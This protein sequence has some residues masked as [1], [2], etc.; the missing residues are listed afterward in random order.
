[1]G[2]PVIYPDR[3]CFLLYIDECLGERTDPRTHRRKRKV[4]Y[5][6]TETTDAHQISPVLFTNGWVGAWEVPS[7]TP[8]LGG[9]P[10][11]HPYI[12]IGPTR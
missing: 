5:T 2:R 3:D 11:T 8:H 10:T 1:M 12:V 9:S 6:T 7:T 4:S